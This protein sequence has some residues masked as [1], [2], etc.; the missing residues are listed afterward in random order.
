MLNLIYLVENEEFNLFDEK[1]L[2]THF[3]SIKINLIKPKR[4]RAA[5]HQWLHRKA[6][7]NTLKNAA[8]H[9]IEYKNKGD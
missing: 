7:I 4:F 2:Q 6:R 1:I 8:K 5:R 9:T 3:C